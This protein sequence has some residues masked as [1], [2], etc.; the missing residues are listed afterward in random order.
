MYNYDNEVKYWVWL[1]SLSKIPVSKLNSLINLFETPYNIYFAEESSLRKL[2]SFTETMLQQLMDKKL[3]DEA[4]KHLENLYKNKIGI[5]TI[6]DE[7]YPYYLKNIYDPP[8]VLYYKGKLMKNENAIAFVGARKATSYGMQVAENLS[9]EAAMRGFTVVSGMARGIDTYAHKGALKAQGRTIAVLG[10]G[11]DIIYPK[12]NMELMENIIN[13]GAVISEY[14]PGTAPIKLN[15][16]ARNRIISGISLGIVVVEAAAGSGSLITATH[17][18]EQGREVFAVPGNIDRVN[19][20]GTNMLI[21]EG[22]KLVMG[23]N[24]ILE[25]L[26]IYNSETKTIKAS[27]FE[28]QSRFKGLDNEERKIVECLAREPMYIENL[29]QTLGFSIKYINPILTML[30]LKGVIEQIPGKIYRIKK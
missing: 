19:S 12:E 9:Y 7:L 8:I 17:A 16:P 3:K 26:S 27:H 10:C 21:K 5:V 4:N 15:F 30:E 11:L 23:I 14:L 13:N 2:P 25:E 18:L 29:A 24:D 1:S 28:D 22:A 6:K 20:E